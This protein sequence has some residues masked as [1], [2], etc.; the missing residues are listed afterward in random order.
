MR[1]L[2]CRHRRHPPP[3]SATSAYPA[4]TRR[5]GLC[6]TRA[7]RP[8]GRASPPTAPA[9]ERRRYTCRRA[10]LRG[11]P[12]VVVGEAVHSRARGPQQIARRTHGGIF[13][14]PADRRDLQDS[15]AHLSSR[16]E[17]EQASSMCAHTVRR[18]TRRR[19]PTAARWCGPRLRMAGASGAWVLLA[20]RPVAEVGTEP[21]GF[22]VGVAD[23]LAQRRQ[24]GRSRHLP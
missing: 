19:C 17:G 2:H 16:I 12:V 22:A 21:R 15:R 8:V 1:P 3:R 24:G 23:R 18:A 11:C 5:G 13:T 6:R 4:R 20:F 10:P 9:R 7:L 14:T